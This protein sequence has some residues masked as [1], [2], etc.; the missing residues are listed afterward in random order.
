MHLTKDEARLLVL[1]L[2]DYMSLVKEY[3]ESN[4][5]VIS[6]KETKTSDIFSRLLEYSTR[7]N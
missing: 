7:M 1:L 2:S 3:L 4:I 6:G 5:D